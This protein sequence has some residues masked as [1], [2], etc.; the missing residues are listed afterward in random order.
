[1]LYLYLIAFFALIISYL[2]N[3]EKGIKSFRVGT[4]KFFKNLPVFFNM[5]ILVSVTL[6]FINDDF[7]IRFL[8]KS[9]MV[10]GL[11]I[12]VVS[13]SI[14]LMPGF[15]AFP[16]A[17]VLLEKGVSFTVL[18][19]FTN[20]LMLVGFVTFPLE[21]QYLGTKIALYRNIFGILLSVIVA[22]VTGIFFGELF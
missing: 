1:M 7:I 8:G 6:Y 2:I 11:I 21:K 22:I 15:V 17:G 18:S 16:L 5:I 12:S 20:S 13:G 14:T 4:K 9:N 19:G 10:E 3:K